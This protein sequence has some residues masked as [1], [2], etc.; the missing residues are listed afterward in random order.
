MSAPSMVIRIAANVDELKRNLAD[1]RAQI[2]ALG[3]SVAKMAATWAANSATL[4]QNARNITAA[5]A[6]VGAST[7]TAADAAKNLKTLD[8]AILQLRASSQPIP[9]LMQQTA[10]KLRA[11]GDAAQHARKETEGGLKA[12]VEGTG[13]VEAFV[14][15]FAVERIV[16]FAKHVVE[17]AARLEDLHLATGISIKGLQEL[18]YVGVSF[19]VD[20]DTM[21]RGV[22]QLSAKLANG[23]QNAVRAVQK[24]GLSVKDLIAAGPEEAF[25]RIGEAVGKVQ[26]PMLKGGLAAELFG[27]KIAKQLL[28]MLGDMRAAMEEAG[29]SSAIM[30][31]ETVKAAHDFEVGWSHAW[32]TVEAIIAG[33][34]QGASAL[35]DKIKE[36]PNFHLSDDSQYQAIVHANLRREADANAAGGVTPDVI[37]SADAV[38]NALNA[39]RTAAL[40]PLTASQKA[41]IVALQKWGEGEKEIAGLV[42]AS[43][44]A[45]HLYLEAQ[46]ESAAATKKSAAEAAAAA[47]L[48]AAAAASIAAVEGEQFAILGK[49]DAAT[50]TRIQLL[51]KEG[52]GQKELA[53]YFHLTDTEIKAIVESAKVFNEILKINNDVTLA[54]GEALAKLGHAANDADSALIKMAPTLDRIFEIEHRLSTVEPFKAFKELTANE[55][56]GFSDPKVALPEIARQAHLVDDA[57]RNM[58]DTFRSLGQTV[59]GTFGTML[60]GLGSMISLLHAASDAAATVRGKGAAAT[61]ADIQLAALTKKQAIAGAIGIGASLAAGS[62]DTSGRAGKGSLIAEGALQ[63][64]GAGAA[65]GAPYAWGTFGISIGAGAAAGA[66]AGW[67]RSGKE[68]R[69]VIQDIGRDFAGIQVSDDFAKMISDLEDQTSLDSAQAMVLTIDQLVQSVGGLTTDNLDMFT[70]HLRDAFSFFERHEISAAQLT[71]VLD[72]NFQT[73]AAAGTDSMG[74]LNDKVKE[75]IRLQ[76]TAGVQSKGIADYLKGQGANALTGGAAV[77]A[78][79]GGSLDQFHQARG[80]VTAA[81]QAVAAGGGPSANLALLE[82]TKAFEALN[83]PE[84]TLQLQNFGTVALGTFSAAVASGASMADAFAA[85]HPQLQA[86]AQGYKD[87]GI[88]IEDAG[89]KALILEDA[90][91]SG[92]PK[93]IAGVDGLTSSMVALDNM[94]ALTPKQFVAMQ[95][96]GMTMYQNL[97]NASVNAGGG[98]KEALIPMQT[99]L[100]AASDEAT[101]LGLHLDDGTQSLIDQSKDLG[102]WRDDVGK[103]VSPIDTLISRIGDLIDTLLGIPKVE[104]APKIVMPP[105][106]D[107][108][109]YQAPGYGSTP[110][111]YASEGGRVTAHGIQYFAGGGNVLRFRPRGLDTVP[112]MLTPGERVLSVAQNRAYESGRG[113]AGAIVVH[114]GSVSLV[115]NIDTIDERGMREAFDTHILP[116]IHKALV[117][118]RRDCRTDIETIAR[119][120]AS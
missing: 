61:E 96:A 83:V 6:Q 42:M 50:V 88:P 100:H 43:Q 92:N 56:P 79:Y 47:K 32:M 113:S 54:S 107:W 36:L 49:L 41:N 104:I 85:I 35:V 14:S 12:F 118:N 24:L 55:L 20:M 93:L 95:G 25:L 15:A 21:A 105:K 64:A 120:V 26:D 117:D 98:A 30:T 71:Q 102:I 97:Y 16:E 58:T 69:Q 108:S 2:E 57:F 17:T 9:A 52:V 109:D 101:K 82:A 111:N 7:L 27:G 40:E 115:F 51:A 78:S 112:A 80:A 116:E 48:Y 3:P 63:G 65:I 87:L 66:I 74:R 28:P 5:I 62:I 94:S 11:V 76:D 84:M 114:E 29:H 99:W 37:T 23:D 46:K 119:R 13:I 45:V 53:T 22:E 91:I 77:L 60:S 110:D 70:G 103:A 106:P 90:V 34:L 1:G 33:T 89:L 67:V 8:A 10:D 19:G 73:F 39:L 86:L 38:K 44:Q 75:L 18:Q 59:G 4:I 31:D 68:W 81:Q 72:K